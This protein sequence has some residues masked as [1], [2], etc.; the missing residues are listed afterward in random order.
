[1]CSRWLHFSLS[2]RQSLERDNLSA[3]FL[4]TDNFSMEKWE[5]SLTVFFHRIISR[6]RAI[7]LRR[8]WWIKGRGL[9]LDFH[10]S[11]KISGNV[12]NLFL[13]LLN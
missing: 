12:R 9:D 13:V 2:P 3:R 11:T 8:W 7:T 6:E 10:L 1:M 4:S 5:N